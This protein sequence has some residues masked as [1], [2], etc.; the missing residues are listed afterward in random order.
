MEL[1]SD[2]ESLEFSMVTLLLLLAALFLRLLTRRVRSL[3]N[4]RMMVAEIDVGFSNGLVE[5]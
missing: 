1:S 5:S 4:L 2:M 3:P